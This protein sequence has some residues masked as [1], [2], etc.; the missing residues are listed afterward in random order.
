[1]IP[2][3]FVWESDNKEELL[4]KLSLSPETIINVDASE[5]KV[6][7]FRHWV[8]ESVEIATSRPSYT[9]LIW[10]ADSMSWEC[11]AVLLKPLEE[12]KDDLSF[13]LVVKNENGL[14]PTIL[15]RCVVEKHVSKETVKNE[16]Y[17]EKVMDCWKNGPSKCIELSDTMSKEQAVQMVDELLM[18]LKDN[19]I[20]GVSEKRLQVIEE[21][22]KF[23]QDINQRN[24]NIKLATGDFLLRTWKLINY[25]IG[26]S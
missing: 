8:N 10:S 22:L 7:E 26:R 1:M 2:K 11:Q 21:V 19:L 20:T 5:I 24:I 4:A 12:L 18:K 3:V 23:S 15:S 16:G 17:W 6:D 25:R 9:I 14:M 13:Y